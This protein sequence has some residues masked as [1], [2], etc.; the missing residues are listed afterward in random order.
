MAGVRNEIA[1]MVGGRQCALGMRTHFHQSGRTD[2]A[3]G[4]R[5]GTIEYLDGLERIDTLVSSLPGTACHIE[6]ICSD[7]FIPTA[8]G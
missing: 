5:H 2:A 8:Q 4:S 1:Q 3:D 6:C 7:L